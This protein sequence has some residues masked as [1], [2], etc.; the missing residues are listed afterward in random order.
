MPCQH[1]YVAILAYLTI[2][3][4]NAAGTGS[5]RHFSEIYYDTFLEDPKR[6]NISYL[7]SY[8]IH[9]R[10][11]SRYGAGG[12]GVRQHIKLKDSDQ[13]QDSFFPSI[14]TSQTWSHLF[15]FLMVAKKTICPTIAI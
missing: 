10:I 6:V 4:G 15:S 13:T 3:L 5:S 7:I 9:F 2:N 12:F 1:L 8:Q 14:S 11:S